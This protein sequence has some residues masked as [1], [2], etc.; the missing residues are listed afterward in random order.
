MSSHPYP[1]Q[2]PPPATYIG[3]FASDVFPTANR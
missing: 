2:S 3:D 1:R